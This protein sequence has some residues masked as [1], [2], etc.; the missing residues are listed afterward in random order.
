MR[1][2]FRVRELRLSWR[3][4]AAALAV[5]LLAACG[6]SD[7]SLFVTEPTIEI[8]EPSTSTTP[9]VAG[10]QPPVGWAVAS[11]GMVVAA[12]PADVGAELPAGPRAR[13][14][15]IPSDPLTEVEEALAATAIVS[16]EAAQ[17]T[18]AGHPGVSIVLEE[19]SA[20]GTVI[21]CYVYAYD[22]DGR[23]LLFVLEAPPE[24][25]EAAQQ[26]LYNVIE[27]GG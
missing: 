7:E 4:A 23:P 11:D 19:T 24:Q 21:R 10:L 8:P 20:A 22:A 27:L 25:W 6:G 18:V 1:Q 16:E 3:T 26:T 13:R 17:V 15:S 12:D 2:A 14:L 5:S 9:V